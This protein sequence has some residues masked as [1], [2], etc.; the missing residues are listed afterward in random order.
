MSAALADPY[1]LRVRDLTVRLGRSPSRVTAVDGVSFD[2]ERGKT[3]GIVGES[4]SGKTTTALSLLRLIA[5][6][7]EIQGGSRILLG[8]RDLMAL[9][10]RELRAVRGREIALVRQNPQASLNPVMTVGAQVVEALRAHVRISRRDARR[11]AAEA[12]AAA[13]LPEPQR[14]LRRYPHELSG[15]MRQRVA[16]AI[17][18]ISSPAVLVADEPTSALDATVQREIL[19]LLRRLAEEKTM[20]MVLITHDL[21]VVADVADH[22]AVMYAGRVVET[23]PAH[24]VINRPVHP[25]T[26]A[27]LNASP[28]LNRRKKRLQ[29]VD[30]STPNPLDLPGG[31][32]FHPRCRYRQAICV[33]QTP[34]LVAS[35]EGSAA[36]WVR[37]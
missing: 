7:G 19:A 36:C 22:I 33:E 13:A 17:A 28:S 35:G 16:I 2:L 29:P 24:E 31:C 10:A 21:N 3:L 11:I 26:E 25:Y 9:S 14:Q 15:G 6:P 5:Q 32:R 30:G 4:G 20:A 1:V 23:G 12:L 37:P 18:T 34:E 8:G 27:L